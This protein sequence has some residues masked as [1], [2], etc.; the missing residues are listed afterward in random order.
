[1]DVATPFLRSINSSYPPIA[2]KPS[3]LCRCGMPRCNSTDSQRLAVTRCEI[4]VRIICL[5]S[6]GNAS[7]DPKTHPRPP[8]LHND[9]LKLRQYTSTCFAFCVDATPFLSVHACSASTKASSTAS[10]STMLT[11]MSVNKTRFLI[12]ALES[13]AF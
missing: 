2:K 4:F 6:Q 8:H 3:S 13:M 12:N 9:L 1:M 5:F 7:D 11:T 10:T